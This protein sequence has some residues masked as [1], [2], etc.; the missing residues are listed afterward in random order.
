MIPTKTIKGWVDYEVKEGLFVITEVDYDA[1]GNTVET[2]FENKAGDQVSNR[3]N[4]DN[5]YGEFAWNKLV[6]AS[7]GITGDG[8]V[9]VEDMLGKFILVDIE[10]SDPERH[11]EGTIFYNVKR[12][13]PTDRTFGGVEEQLGGPTLDITAD[14]LPF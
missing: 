12:T 2:K 1:R 7:T 10:A 11:A 6:S 5:Q 9:A 14:D 4:L 13:L 3:Y 8:G